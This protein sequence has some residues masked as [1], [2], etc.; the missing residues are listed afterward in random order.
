MSG[1]AGRCHQV[2]LDVHVPL[3]S[4]ETAPLELL[5]QLEKEDLQAVGRRRVETLIGNEPGLR[6]LIKVNSGVWVEGQVR[7]IEELRRDIRTYSKV[8][9]WRSIPTYKELSVALDLCYRFLMKPSDSKGGVS[10]NQLAV[11]TLQYAGSGSL[12]AVIEQNL[13]SQYWRN[14]IKDEFERVQKVVHLVLN[15][16]RQWFDYRLPKVLNALSGIQAYVF[17][18]GRLRAGNYCYLA[19][20]LENSFLQG[21]LSTLLDYDVPMSAIRKIE[22]LFKGDESWPELQ[23]RLRSIDFDRTG[24]LPYEKR[25]LLGIL[26]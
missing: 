11:L 13:D 16:S 6:E 7:L 26:R 22:G 24:L 14:A 18:R 4:Q 20:Q 12:K 25:K 5:V 23:S 21:T 2:E 17:E 10:A 8:L 3:F 15:T 9:S 19:A 1:K